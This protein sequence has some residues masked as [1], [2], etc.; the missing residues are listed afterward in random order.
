[1]PAVVTARDTP[2]THKNAAV[3]QRCAV[4]DNMDNACDS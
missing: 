2:G 4:M 1:M 3:R